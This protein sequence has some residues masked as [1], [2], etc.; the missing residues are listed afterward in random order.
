MH[1]NAA[2]QHV[3]KPWTGH[4]RRAPAGD[5]EGAFYRNDT[6]AFYVVWENA[7]CDTCGRLA[8]LPSAPCEDC[9]PAAA[10]TPSTDIVR[11]GRKQ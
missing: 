4:V 8:G 3:R 6:T 10:W 2:V 11:A 5:R 9:P 1:E 7:R